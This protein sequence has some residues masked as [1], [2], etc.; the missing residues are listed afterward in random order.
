MK[1]AYKKPILTTYGNVAEKT[2]QTGFSGLPNGRG[3]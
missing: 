3:R 1:K 2:T